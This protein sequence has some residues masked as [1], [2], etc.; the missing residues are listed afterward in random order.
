MTIICTSQEKD[1]M[2]SVLMEATICPFAV[3]FCAA[4]GSCADCSLIDWHI[5]DTDKEE[6]DGE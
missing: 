5:T 6:D 1:R 2:Q 3:D 4:D